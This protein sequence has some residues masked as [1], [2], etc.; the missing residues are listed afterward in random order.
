MALTNTKKSA[1]FVLSGATLPDAPANFLEVTEEFAFS[2]D[3]PV[4]EFKRINGKLGS[5]SSYVDTGHVT[6]SQSFTIN[7]RSSNS[8]ADALDTH[9]EYGEL[10]KIGGFDEIIDTSTEDEETVTY[11][12]SQTPLRGSIVAYLDGN[13]HT[14]TDAAVADI[15][16]NFPV[17]RVATIDATISAFLDNEGVSVAE[18]NPTVTPNPEPILLVSSADVFTAGGVNLVPDNVSIEMGADIQE[19]YGMGRKNFEMKDYVIKVTA[20]FYPENA[21]YN[22]A[23]SS[24][25]NG[26]VEAIN[27]KLGTDGTGALINGKS[28]DITCSTAKANTFSDSVDKSTLKRSFTWL[29]TG[30]N[31]ISLKH[32]FFA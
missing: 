8:A 28:V 30:D 17:G 26:T 6:I 11:V 19:F 4:E 10:L 13:K 3:V 23:I 22:N 16:F 25:K 21:D 1:L 32:G 14:V 18:A 24:L 27:L 20:D 15:K 7:M 5:N 9:P 31:Q 29:L 2:P 12:N